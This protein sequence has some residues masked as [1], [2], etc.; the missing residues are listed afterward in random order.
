MSEVIDRRTLL[1]GSGVLVGCLTFPEVKK[2]LAQSRRTRKPLLTDTN[3]NVFVRRA[4]G[5]VVERSGDR[6]RLMCRNWD[7][8]RMLAE[9]ARRDFAGFLAQHFVVTPKQH[10]ALQ[11]LGDQ[12]R[13]VIQQ[14]ITHSLED[15]AVP[16]IRFHNLKRSAGVRTGFD[17][18]GGRGTI[19][20]RPGG[21]RDEGFW[22]YAA[23]VLT[24]ATTIFFALWGHGGP[25]DPNAPH[26]PNDPLNQ[27]DAALVD[28]LMH[29][30]AEGYTTTFIEDLIS[31]K[32]AI[33]NQVQGGAGHIPRR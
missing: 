25:T 24:L 18:K 31:P 7:N 28:A 1:R 11:L 2:A 33:G 15:R 21:G 19:T 23:T 30:G 32:A 4:A 17:P 20:F 27:Q 29:G 14:A 16:F 3:F 13:A 5:V 9:H 26:D 10:Q 8:Y 6:Y 12:E 22:E